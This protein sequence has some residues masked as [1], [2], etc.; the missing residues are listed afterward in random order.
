[1]FQRSGVQECLRGF[2]TE[3]RLIEIPGP[4]RRA[5][6]RPPTAERWGASG[7]AVEETQ[8]PTRGVETYASSKVLCI[9]ALFLLFS[10]IFAA[11]A[12]SLPAD[13]TQE[14]R[15]LVFFDGNPGY[16]ER[17]RAIFDQANRYLERES[18]GMTLVPSPTV[19]PI[20]FQGDTTRIMLNELRQ[21]A[22]VSPR[23]N[24]DIAI[25]FT[26]GPLR[27]PNGE[28]WSGV[29]EKRE[30]R[31]III[32]CLN[33]NTLLHEIGHAL[34]LS[35]GSGIML[36]TMKSGYVPMESEYRDSLNNARNLLSARSGPYRYG[37]GTA[38]QRAPSVRVAQ[39]SAE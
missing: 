9:A 38:A 8:S 3:G 39:A 16:E 13:T 2:N 1:M 24:W 18:A 36:S 19:R 25:A 30:S 33:Y 29:I 6:V 20:E 10:V 11:P 37:T 17:I 15:C 26:N 31:H 14:I 7:P 32:K 5:S 28:S 21:A 27:G 34:G 4:S 12:H 22:K 35:H 23:D